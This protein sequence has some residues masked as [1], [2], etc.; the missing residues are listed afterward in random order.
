MVITDRNGLEDE[1]ALEKEESLRNVRE[2]KAHWRQQLAS[3]SEADVRTIH[4][5]HAPGAP[6]LPCSHIVHLL[7]NFFLLTFE[8]TGQS[9]PR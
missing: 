6:P 7:F 4:I 8:R 5:Y 2:G 1:Y 3:E 9:R